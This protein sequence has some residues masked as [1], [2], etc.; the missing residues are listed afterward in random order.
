MFIPKKAMGKRF[1]QAEGRTFYIDIPNMLN[2]SVASLLG[3]PPSAGST[4]IPFDPP[5][6]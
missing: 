1:Q 6:E 3:K 4:H 5:L 2:E